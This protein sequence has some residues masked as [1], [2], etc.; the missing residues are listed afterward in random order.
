MSFQAKLDKRGV[1]RFYKDNEPGKRPTLLQVKPGDIPAEEMTRLLAELEVA[2]KAAEIKEDVQDVK[3]DPGEN[4]PEDINVI[5]DEPKAPVV[6]P[7]PEAKVCV[8]CG[9]AGRYPKFVNL[10]TAWLCEN[11]YRW[12]TVSQVARAMK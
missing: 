11:D 9:E 3:P 7:E 10:K 6:E 1:A 12:A 4:D 8:I 2:Q 5:D